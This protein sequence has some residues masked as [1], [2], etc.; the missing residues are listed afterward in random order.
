MS[1]SAKKISRRDLTLI[2]VTVALLI[3]LAIAFVYDSNNL[4]FNRTSQFE[5]TQDMKIVQ[6]DKH[7]MMFYRRGYECQ[8]SIPIDKMDGIATMIAQEYNFAGQVM[9]Y[10]EYM[11]MASEVLNAQ[12]MLPTPAEGSNVWVMSVRTPDDH[13]ITYIINQERETSAFLY[14]YYSR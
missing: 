1:K 13:D 3:V 5:L 8:I 2:I 4:L 14:V 11:T 6:M 12:A 7:G 9:D 10:D